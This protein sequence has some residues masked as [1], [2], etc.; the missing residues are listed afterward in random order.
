MAKKVITTEE[1]IDEEALSSPISSTKR[2]ETSLAANAIN[3][4]SK[5]IVGT[6]ALIALCAISFW[7]GRETGFND[8]HDVMRG[9]MQSRN[10]M[11][12]RDPNNFDGPRGGLRY[13][14]RQVPTQAPSTNPTTAP[15][16]TIN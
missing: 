8:H 15:S 1:I 6:L 5:L 3:G 10:M 12:D 14:T 9:R 11:F 4:N 16:N 2:I 13:N 7:A